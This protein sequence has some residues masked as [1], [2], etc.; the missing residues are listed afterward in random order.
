MSFDHL[1]VVHTRLLNCVRPSALQGGHHTV[2]VLNRYTPQQIHTTTDTHHNRY[3]LQ[4]IHTTTDTHHNRY[5]PQHIHTTTDTHHNRYTPQQI[6]TTT[7]T[8]HKRWLLPKLRTKTIKKQLFLINLSMSLLE[9]S[10]NEFAG[11]IS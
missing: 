9:S 3:M 5:I 8:Y 7:D 4:Q 1:A 11:I 6:H 10:L 2:V